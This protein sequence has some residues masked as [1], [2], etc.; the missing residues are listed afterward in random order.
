MYET[1]LKPIQVTPI[2]HTVWT[3]FL[4]GLFTKTGLDPYE[5]IAIAL[6]RMLD[7]FNSQQSPNTY[8]LKAFIWISL[9]S[10]PLLIDIISIV[11]TGKIGIALS[12]FSFFSGWLITDSGMTG[13]YL[14][15]GCAVFASLY[16]RYIK[17][18]T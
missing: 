14:F 8:L 15:V 13:A 3:G 7:I 1:G 17:K 9:V 4:I 10:I 16:S 6:G 11:K 12:V 18:S 5:Q 2:L